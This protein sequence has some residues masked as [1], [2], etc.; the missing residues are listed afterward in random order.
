MPD[1]TRGPSVDAE[2][3]PPVASVGPESATPE[4]D[5][6][7]NAAVAEQVAQTPVVAEAVEEKGAKYGLPKAVED[8]ATKSPTL[9]SKLD[10][11]LAD[12]WVISQGADGGGS[13]CDKAAKKIVYDPRGAVDPKALVQTLAH[14][15]GHATFE[16]DPYVDF[17]T[18]TKEEY[19]EVNAMSSLKD[20]GEATITNIEIREEILNA[21][22]SIDIGVAGAKAEEY[23]ALYEAGKLGSREALR[24][25]IA[26]VFKDGENPSTDPTKT[27]G[28]YYGATYDKHWDDNHPPPA[29]GGP[30]PTVAPTT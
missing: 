23:K 16:A 4:Q 11:L 3:T 12:G 10:T 26:K 17:G 18:L 30:T 22:P 9:V 28:E 6:V 27:Y 24:I 25:E 20:E 19:V 2:V 14:E 21:D 15:V 8:I 5:A 7:G 1:R 13:F 29:P